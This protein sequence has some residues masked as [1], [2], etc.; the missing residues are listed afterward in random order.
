[1]AE[2][3]RRWPGLA[4]S[5]VLAA[6]TSGCVASGLDFRVDDRLT[7]T[8]PQDRSQVTLPV[9]LT[10]TMRGFTVVPPGSPG[11]SRDRGYFA[12]LVDRAPQPP[13]ESLTWFARGDSRCRPADGCPDASYLT[14]RG[15]YTT[16]EQHLTFKQLPR[17]ADNLKGK[18]RHSLIVVLLDSSG[19]R[20]GE[21][22][23]HLDV[24]VRRKVL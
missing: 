22:A 4:L 18:E 8:A 9:T 2:Q 15:V 23:F 24:I 20:I 6:S 14:A 7:I 19:R 16:T 1:M 3:A 5:L 13:G 21:S 10:W 11:T 12:V 17:P